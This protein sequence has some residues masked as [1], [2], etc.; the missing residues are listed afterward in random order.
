MTQSKNAFIKRMKEDTMKNFRALLIK[1]IMTAAVLLITLG[2]LYGVGFGDILT[3]SL[4]LTIASYFLGDMLV[5]PQFGN[6]AATVADF[7]LAWVGTWLVGAMII[8][9][10]I[11][12]GI[13]SFITALALTVCEAFFHNYLTQSVMNKNDD[14]DREYNMKPAYQNEIAEEPYP[15]VNTGTQNNTAM[16]STEGFKTEYAEENDTV[17][18][19][20]LND[21]SQGQKEKYGSSTSESNNSKNY[22]D[23]YGFNNSA[24]NL[25]DDTTESNQMKDQKTESDDQSLYYTTS[26]EDYGMADGKTEA[27]DSTK[28]KS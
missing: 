20:S 5:L 16:N 8:E 17:T 21:K 23:P 1:F 6:T 14:K 18:K 19:N 10:P 11:R 25:L 7:A 3:I 4:V 28:N 22:T 27:K 12:L 15:E 2:L 24:W 26:A 13:A 9:A